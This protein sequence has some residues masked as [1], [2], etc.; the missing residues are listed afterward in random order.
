[1]PVLLGT[2]APAAF[3]DPI[4]RQAWSSTSWRRPRAARSGSPRAAD[5]AILESLFKGLGKEDVFVARD[6]THALDAAEIDASPDD[7]I[8]VTGSLYIVGEAIRYLSGADKPEN[9]KPEPR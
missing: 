4:W 3:A 6:V 9:G 2:A 8:L 5:P 7:M 1:M